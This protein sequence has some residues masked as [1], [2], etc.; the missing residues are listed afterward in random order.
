MK[1]QLKTVLKTMIAFSM[2]AAL[3][4]A[5]GCA[6]TP[7]E[8][9]R[10]A[11]LKGPTGMG[12]SYLMQENTTDYSV[13]LYDAAD[14]V[15]ACGYRRTRHGQQVLELRFDGLAGCLRTPEGG[16]SRQFVVIKKNGEPAL[17]LLSAREAARLMGAPDNFVLPERYN[18]AYKAMGDAVAAPVARFLGENFLMRLSEAAYNEHAGTVATA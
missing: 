4:L 11:A 1:K 14:S 8:P 17:R 3:L 10:I 6:K 13:E 5:A 18:D 9:M 12:I 2:L 15:V 7:A 16:S